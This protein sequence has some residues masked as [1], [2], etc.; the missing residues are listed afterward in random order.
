MSKIITNRLPGTIDRMTSGAVTSEL[1]IRT[2]AGELTSVTSN[3]S[4]EQMDFKAGD[5]I[6]AIFKATEVSLKRE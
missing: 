6:F 1:V 4:V 2:V 3:Y 5:R